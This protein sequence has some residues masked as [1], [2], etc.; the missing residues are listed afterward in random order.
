MSID[1]WKNCHQN[2]AQENDAFD[3]A[4]SVDSDKAYEATSMGLGQIMGNNYAKCGYTSAKE[5]YGD[6]ATGE[7]HN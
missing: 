4:I 5:M 1:F 6:F 7:Q 3:F 2:Q